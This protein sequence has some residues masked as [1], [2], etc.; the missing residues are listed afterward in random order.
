LEVDESLLTGESLA[1]TKNAEWVGEAAT[2]LA[3]RQNMAFAGALVARGRGKGVVVATASAT[4][5]G[6]LALDVIGSTGG[7]PPLLLRMERFT[8]YVAV[9][10]LVAAVSIG[11][12]GMVY[13]R[14][15]QLPVRR[16]VDVARPPRCCRRCARRRFLD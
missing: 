13:S 2:T 4:H 15:R 5:V 7:K 10:T 11:L 1:V 12:L 16:P 14:S 3:D 9:G 8:N 6:Q